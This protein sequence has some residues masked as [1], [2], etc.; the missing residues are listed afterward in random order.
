MKKNYNN[1]SVETVEICLATGI[2]SA[3]GGGAYDPGDNPDLGGGGG[4]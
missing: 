4:F 3:V 2:C 1:P